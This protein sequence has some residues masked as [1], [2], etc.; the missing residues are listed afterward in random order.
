MPRKTSS[1]NKTL[2]KAAVSVRL[3]RRIAATFIILTAFLFVFIIYLSFSK[4]SVIIE[5]DQKMVSIDF[6]LNI[7]KNP[8]TENT[9]E[10]EVV[11]VVVQ[12]ETEEEATGELVK[13]DGVARGTVV[14]VN[15]TSND[16]TL[17]RTTRLLT[18][19]EKLFHLDK[20]IVVP[21][22]GEVEAPIYADESGEEG[23]IGPSLF[24]IPGL[25]EG[26]QDK[27]YGESAEATFINIEEIKMVTQDDLDRVR[28][29]L[30]EELLEKGKEE[31]KFTILKDFDGQLFDG[32]IIEEEFDTEL[33]EQTERFSLSMEFRVVGIFFSQEELRDI[34]K[35]KLEESISSDVELVRINY[36]TIELDP[37]RYD[38]SEENATLRVLI[39]GDTILKSNSQIFDKNRLVG[40]DKESAI[41][42]FKNFDAVKSVTIELKPFWL[43]RIPE[44]RDHIE[45]IIKR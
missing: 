35:N 9:I 4:A 11:S 39:N 41:D 22:G 40:M 37:S 36:D 31:L 19:D 1:K 8:S 5:A 21:A 13:E 14:F 38:L 26:L 17:I 16:Q 2:P 28:D 34:A 27:I 24:T 12:G 43:K 10:G 25:W 23:I 33:N 20:K 18:P 32:E 7:E 42:Y 29:K 45:I 15:K 44:L 30:K 6:S 3:Y